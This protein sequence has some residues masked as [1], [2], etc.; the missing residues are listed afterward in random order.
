MA[1][2]DVHSVDNI[3]DALMQEFF[4]WALSRPR[5]S[6]P[7]VAGKDDEAADA[8]DGKPGAADEAPD[9]KAGKDVSDVIPKARGLAHLMNGTAD[10]KADAKADRKVNDTACSKSPAWT[11]PIGKQKQPGLDGVRHRDSPNSSGRGVKGDSSGRGTRPGGRM[12]SRASHDSSAHFSMQSHVHT[13][14][15]NTDAQYYYD[16]HMNPAAR[17]VCAITTVRCSVDLATVR[18]Q[19][20]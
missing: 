16:M 10:G 8:E 15:D 6:M 17:Q 12:S 19:A 2:L 14:V 18:R 4:L 5:D 20:R 11:A 9:I 1:R 7:S 13:N 3:S